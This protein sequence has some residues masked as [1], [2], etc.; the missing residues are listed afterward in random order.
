ME[1]RK[2]MLVI[3]DTDKNVETAIQDLNAAIKRHG[4]GVLHTYDLKAKLKEKG[5]DLPNESR[6]LEICNPQQAA[7]VL[8]QNMAV[9]LALPCRIAVYEENGRTK[10]GT[11]RPTALLALFPGAGNLATVAQEVEDAI[12]QIVDEAK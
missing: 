11:F 4:F 3:V 5:I 2:A 12:L 10:I 6:I 7:H 9:S 8:K 1:R